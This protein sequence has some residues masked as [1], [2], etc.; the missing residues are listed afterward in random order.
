MLRIINLTPHTITMRN[1]EG[2]DTS[3]P[4][5]GLARVST[6]P[7]TA[8]GWDVT[9][10]APCALFTAPSFG[11]VEGLPA[12]EAGTIFIVSAMVA[13]CCVGRPDVFSPGTG[14]HDGTIRENGQIKAVTRLI[15]AP[16]A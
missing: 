14:P 13:A 5:S 3:I 4:S 1:S 11:A 2:M 6:T 8:L 12:P 16:Q 9:G 10:S 7:G 15:Q